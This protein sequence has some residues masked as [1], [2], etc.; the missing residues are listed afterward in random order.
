MT[1]P[2]SNT[3]KLRHHLLEQA[4][5]GKKSVAEL[6]PDHESALAKYHIADYVGSHT[7]KTDGYDKN[8]LR[9]SVASVF[10]EDDGGYKKTYTFESQSFNFAVFATFVVVEIR[11]NTASVEFLVLIPPRDEH[12]KEARYAGLMKSQ[13]NDDLLVLLDSNASA[14]TD[15]EQH[16]EALLV[17]LQGNLISLDVSNKEKQKQGW[18]S[19]LF[20]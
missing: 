6:A 16:I 18:F 11:P 19:R 1:S 15:I 8:D 20:R 10:F 7:A 14:L 5:Y 2:Q 9:K 12:L 4:I 17:S 3:Q 13:N